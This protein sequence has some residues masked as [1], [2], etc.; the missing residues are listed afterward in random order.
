MGDADTRRKDRELPGQ[1]RRLL[2]A[3][4]RDLLLRR[5]S[6]CLF[7]GCAVALLVGAGAGSVSLSVPAWL[8]V[9]ACPCTAAVVGLLL[10]AFGRI[11]A[12]RLLI[13][14]DARLG[15][16]E[17]VS[18]AFEL[19]QKPGGGRF[20]E[21]L[22]EDAAA[23]L[24]RSPRRAALGPLRL[25]FL[26]FLPLLAALT[27][28]ALLFPLDV[29]SLFPRSAQAPRELVDLGE[30]LQAYGQRLLDDAA[31]GPGRTLSLPQ[32]LAQLGKDFSDRKVSPEEGLDRI[33]QMENR[34]AQ[35]YQLQSQSVAP[36][37][38]HRAGQEA[39]E[40][41]NGKGGAAEKSDRV[42]QGKDDSRSADRSRAEQSLRDL[43]GA[44][45][46]LRDAKR[47]LLGQ[48]TGKDGKPP[49]VAQG[50]S[51]GNPPGSGPG[52]AGSERGNG[53]PGEGAGPGDRGDQTGPDGSSGPGTAP[54]ERKH[55]APSTLQQGNGPGLQAGGT[56]GEG[57]STRLLARAVP[58]WTGSRL[59]EEATIDSYAR[60]AESALARDE[61][62]LPLRQSVRDYFTAIGV[63]GTGR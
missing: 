33:D 7:L 27:V 16:R 61:V 37:S 22:V 23:L 59:P 17:L 53:A 46:T 24:A 60:Q 15:S 47:R 25:R 4:R 56:P 18:T 31:V 28:A 2:R 58:G 63:S 38:Q 12:R 5:L 14:A 21:T 34:L 35:E 10:G 39:G 52:D 40:G 41:Q 54:A 49:S 44:M 57:D 8:I 51:I 32:E 11:D 48:G 9:C 42:A 43:G 55:G 62:P 45:D 30:D 26:P 6:L 36:P 3:A 20:A 13:E 50:P 1:V 29:R 19:A